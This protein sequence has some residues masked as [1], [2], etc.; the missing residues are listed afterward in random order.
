MKRRI[1][2]IAVVLIA[3]LCLTACGNESEY[4]PIF[5]LGEGY[6]LDGDVISGTVVGDEYISLFSVFTTNER[7]IIFGDSS[8]ETF[9]ESGI[10]PL[11]KGNN[12]LV[13]RFIQEGEE[14]EYDLH[15][16]YIPIRSFSVEI[17]D[18]EKTYHIGEKFDKSTIR[19]IA[20]TENGDAV[21]VESYYAEYEFSELGEADVGI[22]LGNMYESIAV[23]VTE[24]Y[25]P[26]LDGKYSADGVTYALRGEEAVL[27]SAEEIEGF[28]AVPRAVICGGREYPVTEIGNGAFARTMLTSVLIPEG[29]RKLSTGVFSGCEYLESVELPDS[30]TVIGMQAFS[31]CVSL[32]RIV[33]PEALEKLEYGTF[34]GCEALF[35]IILPDTLTVIGERAFADCKTLK[36]VRFSKGLTEIGNEA[37]AGCVSLSSVVLG[38]LQRIGDRAFQDC[39]KLT[40]FAIAD[41][42]SLGEDILDGTNATVY[43]AMAGRVLSYVAT[44]AI[45]YVLLQENTPCL[46]SLPMEFA[47]EDEYPYN[48]LFALVLLDGVISALSDYAVEYEAD[49]CGVLSATLTWRD[50]SHSFSIFVSYT[51][52]V[53]I[54]TDTR[55]ARY[56]LDPITKTATLVYLPEYVKPSKI[57]IPEQE[58]LFLVPTT[59]SCP[60]GE[61]MVVGVQEGASDECQNISTLYIPEISDLL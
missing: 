41:A 47:I 53:L 45:P 11:E 44:N 2:C 14:R 38:N 25:L 59:L 9:L 43:T 17:L 60:D 22:E 27:L 39:E 46:V 58:G 3:L 34:S 61:Y 6:A 51:E 48:D 37:F 16:E 26:T 52:T 12:R 15:I 30:V 19:V 32:D 21:T 8:A 4:T 20:T 57:Y 50:F 31:D 42:V 40:S 23:M 29:V 5:D 55:G 18:A 54:D 7:F 24:E 33:L 35:R 28:F 13:I 56:E 36:S 1:F 49:A 10:I